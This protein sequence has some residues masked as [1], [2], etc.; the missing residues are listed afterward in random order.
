L[1]P[2]AF[3]AKTIGER[4]LG[5]VDYNAICIAKRLRALTVD[6]IVDGLQTSI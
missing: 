5:V 3:E 2:P 6:G 1:L 4:A